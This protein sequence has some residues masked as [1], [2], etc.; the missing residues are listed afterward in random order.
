MKSKTKTIVQ[1]GTYPAFKKPVLIVMQGGESKSLRISKKVA[2]ALIAS[3]M[4]S[5]G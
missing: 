3:G 4:S 1:V 2:A 5:E